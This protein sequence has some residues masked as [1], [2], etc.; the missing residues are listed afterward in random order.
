RFT[1]CRLPMASVSSVSTT[2]RSSASM[3][4]RTWSSRPATPVASDSLFKSSMRGSLL[5]EPIRDGGGEIGRAL[6]L[7]GV[8]AARHDD[9]LR[10]REVVGQPLRLLHR[11]DAVLLAGDDERRRPD[12]AEASLEALRRLRLRQAPQSDVPALHRERLEEGVDALLRD[13]RGV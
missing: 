11:H 13:A 12:R 10:V 5:C 8:A 6:L 2:P 9:E 1:A 7:D 4:S 3:I